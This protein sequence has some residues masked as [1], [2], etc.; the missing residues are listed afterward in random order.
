MTAQRTRHFFHRLEL[1]THRVGTPG[2]KELACPSRA[3]VR[4]EMLE[5]L[6]Q[7]VGPHRLQVVLHQLTKLYPLL[8][9]VVLPTLEQTPATVLENRLVAISLELPGFLSTNLVHLFVHR[10]HD[11][12]TIKHMHRVTS[13]VGGDFQVS[14]PSGG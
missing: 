7:D 8:V 2:I 11:V 12:K 14:L 4:P 13:A 10:L 1:A 3:S 9:S 6:L 5:V